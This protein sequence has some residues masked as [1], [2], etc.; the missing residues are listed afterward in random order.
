MTATALS[1]KPP[2]AHSTPTSEAAPSA[3]DTTSQAS[4]LSNL[5]QQRVDALLHVNNLLLHEVTVVQKAGLKAPP[6]SP[7]PA[8]PPASTSPQPKT[9]AQIKSEGTTVTPAS[10]DG[11]TKVPSNGTFTTT[12]PTTTTPATVAAPPLPQAAAL[13]QRKYIEYMSRLKSNIMFLVS[14]SDQTKD[15]TRPPYPSHL[16]P[17]PPWLGSGKEEGDQ[18]LESLRDGY[19]RL[20]ELWPDWKPPPKVHPSGQPGAQQAQ[21]QQQHQQPQQHA[22]AQT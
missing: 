16:E 20:R 10:T 22:Q 8:A 15:K 18:Q 3:P 9:A 5:D 2:S 11:P 21:Q 7:Q 1:A 19:A 6:Q 12:P 17:P 4:G 14:I 13:N